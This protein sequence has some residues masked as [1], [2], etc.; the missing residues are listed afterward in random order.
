VVMHLMAPIFEAHDRER[1]HTIGVS[2]VADD[3]SQIL[4]RAKR[5]L[6]QFINVSALSDAEAARAIRELEADI[7]VDL[8]GYTAGCRT[9]I[10]AY[11]PGPVQV[12]YLGYA[13]TS[14][15]TF[16]DYLIADG[17]TVPGDFECFFS[18]RVVRLPHGFLPLGAMDPSA[19]PPPTRQDLGLPDA[20]FVFCAFCSSYKYNPVT[21]DVWMHLLREI[22]RGVLWLRDGES[23]MRAN[24]RREASAR[25]VDPRRLLFAPK[26]PSMNDHLARHGQADL[27]LDTLPF[28][29]HSTARDAL[30]SGLPVLT[31]LGESFASRVAGSLLAALDLPSLVAGT[32]DEYA[33]RALELARHPELLASLKSQLARKLQNA[34]RF[35]IH[36][37]CVRLESAFEQMW[38][39]ARCGDAPVSFDVSD[40][41]SL[42]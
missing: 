21:F 36:Q 14:G 37:H 42:G 17:I 7:V 40:A 29:G 23:I 26:L 8:T 10:F 34:P 15:A 1:F 2:L 18:E 24:L 6:S 5:A 11:R 32:L 27:F 16:F 12:S 9:P 39:R 33:S 30:L 20:A 13:G 19:A 35:G 25:R 22:P 38:L 28:G 41:A 3:D 4:E 31:C